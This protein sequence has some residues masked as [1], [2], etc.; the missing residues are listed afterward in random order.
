M[1]VRDSRGGINYSFPVSNGLLTAEH[2]KRLG[3]ALWEFL[4]FIDR[5]TCNDKDG[6]GLVLGGRPITCASIARSLGSSERAVRANCRRLAAHGYIRVQRAPHGLKVWVTK[7]KKFAWKRPTESR[8]PLDR[9]GEENCHSDRY[10]AAAQIGRNVPMHIDN[11]QDRTEDGK[12]L[13]LWSSVGKAWTALDL[14]YPIGSLE[15]RSSW[16]SWFE[17]GSGQPLSL[18]MEQCICCCKDKNIRV[19]PEFYKLKCR[20]EEREDDMVELEV[21]V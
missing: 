21:P 16:Q 9:R 5:T 10:G 12:E 7:S 2:R 20:V 15:F 18:L 19:P 17:A 1:K 6:C 13:P 14:T 4:W 8:R 11:Q 3:S